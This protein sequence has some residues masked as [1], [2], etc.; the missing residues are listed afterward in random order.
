MCISQKYNSLGPVGL[1]VSTF[2]KK[3]IGFQKQKMFLELEFLR[4]YACNV[5]EGKLQGIKNKQKSDGARRLYISVVLQCGLHFKNQHF[6]SFYRYRYVPV[7]SV[8]SGSGSWGSGLTF[9]KI[10]CNQLQ[11]T[12]GIKDKIIGIGPE[13]S[14]SLVSDVYYKYITPLNNIFENNTASSNMQVYTYTHTH[15]HHKALCSLVRYIT[16]PPMQS[17]NTE[18]QTS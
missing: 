16:N 11:T 6:Y 10:S 7:K 12:T 15:T 8:S 17:N 5:S 4:L 18:K 13:E 3:L 1:R 9:K 14:Y 2:F